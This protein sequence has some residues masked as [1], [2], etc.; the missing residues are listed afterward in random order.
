MSRLVGRVGELDEEV[1][2]NYYLYKLVIER[3]ISITE[4]EQ[5][6]L[7]ELDCLMAMYEMKNDYKTAV[8][9]YQEE[10]HRGNK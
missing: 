2:E 8:R 1:E 4:L 7:F 5:M 3:I 10:K 6:T 9:E